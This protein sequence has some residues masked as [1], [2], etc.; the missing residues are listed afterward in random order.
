MR[1]LRIVAF[2]ILA[3][4]TLAAHAQQPGSLDPRVGDDGVIRLGSPSG[5]ADS[6]QTVPGGWVVAVN[7]SSFFEQTG[8]WRLD[9]S[10]RPD[11]AFGQSG[12]V[13][14][15]VFCDGRCQ[16]HQAQATAD[17]ILLVTGP[18]ASRA[19]R[20]VRLASDGQPDVGF[21]AGGVAPAPPGSASPQYTGVAAAAD[22]RIYVTGF[23]SVPPN[24]GALWRL[25][26]QGRFDAAFGLAR[27]PEGPARSRSGPIDPAGRVIVQSG[28]AILR[29]LP[30]GGRDPTF[31]IGGVSHVLEGLMLQPQAMLL[32]ASGRMLVLTYSSS[33]TDG[34]P[35]LQAHVVALDGNGRLDASFADQGI[36]RVVSDR[37]GEDVLP[38]G[39]AIDA[40][41]RIVVAATAG[42]WSYFPFSVQMRRALVARFG[43]DGRPDL[44]F[45]PGGSTTFWT[46]SMTEARAVAVSP[47]GAIA[48]AGTEH[49]P[50]TYAGKYPQYHPR[51]AVYVLNG[52]E[53]SAP[54]PLH[55]QS[56]IE[57]FHAEM[58]H[59]FMTTNPAEAGSLDRGTAWART[60]ATFD[61]WPAAEGGRARLPLLERPA[62]CAEILALLH[63]VPGRVR[64]PPRAGRLD[65]R[66]RRLRPWRFRKAA[67]APPAAGRSIGPTTTD[68]R[69]RPTIAT[70]P[71]RRCSTR[72]S[73]RGGSSKATRSRGSSLACPNPD[74]SRQRRDGTPASQ[75]SVGRCSM[76]GALC[77]CDA[78][79]PRCLFSRTFDVT[80]TPRPPTGRT[81]REPRSPHLHHDQP[82]PQHL[83]LGCR[84]RPAGAAR[85]PRRG[86]HPAGPCRARQV[87]SRVR[88][89]RLR[90]PARRPVHAPGPLPR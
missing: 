1:T 27:F 57:Y 73:S 10:G 68:G 25:D 52:G 44:R 59:Y 42:D 63:A 28:G 43:A 19:D 74:A 39:L 26:R 72:W 14:A 40:E 66:R 18:D 7:A 75:A 3:A 9:S 46:G 79:A 34:T 82:R 86:R 15:T 65:V 5:S 71:T 38:G 30:D 87:A 2:T 90:R 41:R 58:G 17:G 32:D 4:A 48:I 84:T 80:N 50:P 53:T 12:F 6:V 8:V 13:S 23:P 76:A 70:R 36:A 22:G 83:R 16:I 29:F 51:P 20:V 81:L 24:S 62:L 31:G 89:A 85:T 55:V 47:D 78:V 77:S 21:G 60:G 67:R 61:V 56:S 11:P 35:D 45:A 33:S 49:E 37:P 54:R 88:P 64:V 69:S